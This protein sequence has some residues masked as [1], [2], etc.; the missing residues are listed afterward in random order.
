M[1]GT[2]HRQRF[3]GIRGLFCFVVVFRHGQVGE[4]RAKHHQPY[5]A[6]TRRG[7]KELDE[8]AAV[9][10]IQIRVAEVLGPHGAGIPCAG[11]G[12]ARAKS[13]PMQPLRNPLGWRSLD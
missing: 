3:F 11:P 2:I 10:S 1:A 13:E 5:G 12:R 9:S 4:D 8:P 6:A 7:G